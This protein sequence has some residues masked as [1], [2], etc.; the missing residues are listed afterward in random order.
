MSTPL[1]LGLA[2]YISPTTLITAPTVA[3]ID[4][5]TIGVPGDDPTPAAEHGRDLDHV[6]PGDVTRGRVH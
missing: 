4:W 5:S 2:P 1:P 3:G 6:R